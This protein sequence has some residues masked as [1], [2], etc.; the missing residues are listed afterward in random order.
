MR[1]TSPLQRLNEVD[2]RFDVL[3]AQVRVRWHDGRVPFHDFCVRI[4]DGFAQVLAIDEHPTA[5]L[6]LLL[7]PP[8]ALPRRTQV[9]T[10]VEGVTCNAPYAPV[11]LRA[12]LGR[13]THLGRGRDGQNG[14]CPE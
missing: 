4:D 10:P 9:V 7:F 8:Q 6:Q 5:A 14:P 3:L 13:G 1:T 2:E 12:P 11:Q